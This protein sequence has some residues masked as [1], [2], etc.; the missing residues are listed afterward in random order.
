[1]KKHVKVHSNRKESVVQV[2]QK[3]SQSIILE[4]SYSI[5]EELTYNVEQSI[6]DEIATTSGVKNS[7]QINKQPTRGGNRRTEGDVKNSRPWKLRSSTTS[8]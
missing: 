7:M 2:I 4:K 5:V 1:M 6:D 3:D 8:N